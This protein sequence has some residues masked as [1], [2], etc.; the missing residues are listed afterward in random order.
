M[1]I[2]R[3]FKSATEFGNFFK[4]ER[5]KAEI[6]KYFI[7]QKY[8]MVY[9]LKQVL[10]DRNLF[11]WKV[12]SHNQMPADVLINRTYL[13]HLPSYIWGSDYTSRPR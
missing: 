6:G 5:K 1:K 2:C 13:P 4:L 3:D 10:S 12:W 9:L 11:L 7:I 8:E